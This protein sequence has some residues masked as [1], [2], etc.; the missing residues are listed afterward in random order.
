MINIAMKKNASKTKY[1]GNKV[2]YWDADLYMTVVCSSVDRFFSEN[3]SFLTYSQV[4]LL[5]GGH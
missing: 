3:L 2:C 4:A 1:E 5:T